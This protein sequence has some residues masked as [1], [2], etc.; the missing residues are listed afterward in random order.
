MLSGNY[1]ITELNNTQKRKDW[2]TTQLH[3][4]MSQHVDGFNIDI[5]DAT[6]N[7]TSDTELLSKFV[8]EVY[9]TFKE[10]NSDYQVISILKPKNQQ[11]LF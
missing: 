1:P 7:G 9:N 5:E 10:A 2:I 8:E 4:V 3:S 6:R 11:D